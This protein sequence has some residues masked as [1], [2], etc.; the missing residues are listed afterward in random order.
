[1]SRRALLTLG[2]LLA[3]VT[4]RDGSGPQL[5]FARVAVAPVLPSDAG[6]A[7]FGL[8]IDRVRII[9]M[10]PLELPDT[11]ADTTV[12]LPPEAQALDLD[13]RVPIVSS[14]T[15]ARGAIIALA[16]TVPLF[17]GSALVEVSSG[18]VS[19]PTEIPI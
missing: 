19:E 15:P 5:Q 4:C 11:L 8:S 9:V 10:R 2:L 3:L 16:G 1:M 6:L 13:L 7:T 14:P 12:N 18:V 17:E